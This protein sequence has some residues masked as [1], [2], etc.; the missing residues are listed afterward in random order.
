[1]QT[2]D[3][4]NLLSHSC[5]KELSVLLIFFLQKSHPEKQNKKKTA[6]NSLYFHI[7]TFRVFQPWIYHVPPLGALPAVNLC[8]LSL[9]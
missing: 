5:W 2:L 6:L 3:N 9:L 4:I 1:M 8:Y 7:F